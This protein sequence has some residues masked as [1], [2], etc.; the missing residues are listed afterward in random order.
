MAEIPKATSATYMNMYTAQ[1]C[2]TR[3]ALDDPVAANTT[4]HPI[5]QKATTAASI[6]AI[7]LFIISHHLK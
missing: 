6:A 1:Y 5:A 3:L 4:T 7:E 2:P